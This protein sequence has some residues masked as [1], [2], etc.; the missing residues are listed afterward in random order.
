L[1][2]PLSISIH[3]ITPTATNKLERLDYV[4]N[5]F[6]ISFVHS[7][8]IYSS[9]LLNVACMPSWGSAEKVTWGPRLSKALPCYSC[10]I[11]ESSPFIGAT[12][13]GE[14]VE[15]CTKIDWKL[16]PNVIQIIILLLLFKICH[17]N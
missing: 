14:S 2:N 1:H 15:T 4:V 9:L 11:C 8:R 16:I 12:A 17:L 13:W 3:F 5:N 10:T 7:N 6:Q